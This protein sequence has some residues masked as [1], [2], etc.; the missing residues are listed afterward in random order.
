MPGQ[1]ESIIGELTAQETARKTAQGTQLAIF[2]E[3]T[4]ILG[5]VKDG[6]KCLGSSFE[7]MRGEIQ[8]TFSASAASHLENRGLLEQ[9]L[10]HVAKV[11]LTD[12][13]SSR[14]VDAQSE[15]AAGSLRDEETHAAKN[16]SCEELMNIITRL[17]CLVNDTN[18]QGRVMSGEP[19]DIIGDLLLTL[20][21]MRSEG[22]LQ[23][24]VMSGLINLSICSTCR[25]RHL[26][27]L[28]TSLTTVYAALLQTRLVTVNHVGKDPDH[29]MRGL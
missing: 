2:N 29:G 16:E 19:K 9:I 22:F 15:S 17:C 28:R 14:V 8:T 11:S 6:V 25:Q 10:Q 12:Q 23:A 21:L 1:L 20:E 18:L 24:G 4:T 3:Q 27:N 5:G 13:G 7:T 26:N